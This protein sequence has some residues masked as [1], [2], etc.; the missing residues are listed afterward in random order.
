M[1]NLKNHINTGKTLLQEKEQIRA[2]E[3]IQ[4][5][6]NAGLSGTGNTEKLI[7][8]TKESF[9]FGVSVGYLKRRKENMNERALT[10]EDRET[11]QVLKERPEVAQIL[12]TFDSLPEEDKPIA[13]EACIKLLTGKATAEEM[14]AEYKKQKQ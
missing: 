7:D 11:L 3:I 13:F 12:K 8:L 9:S 4:L 14:I 5:M 6:F 10:Q 1:R 2:S